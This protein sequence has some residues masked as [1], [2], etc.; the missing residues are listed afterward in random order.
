[1]STH[2][3]FSAERLGGGKP[4]NSRPGADLAGRAAELELM[5]SL[6]AGQGRDGG[7]LLLRGAPG[8]G[9]T[10]LLDAAAVRA[11]DAG[12][13]VLRASGVEFEA[14][15]KFSALHQ[16]LYP[17]RRQAK[18]LAGH[19]RDVLDRIFGLAPGPSP[20]PPA[21]STAVLALLGEVAVERPL[22][23]IVDDMPCV[24]RASATV[25]G[26]VVR[27]I[28][29][30]PVVFLAAAR[31]G[32]E[33]LSHQLQL[34]V[35][36]IGPLAAQSAAELL[37]VRWPG[38]A[39]T[40]RRRLLA[41]AA[42]NPL[43]LQE[44][45]AAL[46]SRQRSG[47]DPLPAFLALSGRL[48]TAFASAVE[49]LPAPTRR[50][51]L[52]AALNADACLTTIRK[53]ARDSAGVDDLAPA[54]RADLVHVDA[55]DGHISFRYP[56][57]RAAIVHLASPS[58][59]RG[60][61]RSLAAALADSPERR[62]W[63]LAEAATGPDESVARALDEAALA[64][65]R[66]GAPSG[67][68]A[69][70][71]DET[72]VSDRRRVAAS[73]AVAWLMRAGEL[74]PDPADRSRRLVEAAYL[75]TIT[76]QLEDVQRL[77]ADAGQSPD[78]STGLVFAAT[79]HLLT[80]DEGD[81]DAAY[82]LLARALDD[83]T[84]TAKGDDWG[85][86]GILYALLLVSLYALRPEPWQLLKTA[87]ARFDP[88]AVTPFRL[89]YDAYVDPTRAPEALRKGL[90]DAFAALPADAA[91]WQLIPLAF[92][93]V[94]MDTLSDYRYLVARMIERERDGGAIAMV[95]PALMLLCHDS[96][97][98]G[99]WDEAESLAQEGLDLA[100]VYGYHFWERQIRALLASG[101]A[102]RGD[103]DLAR[104]RSEE[105][106]NWAAPRGIEVTEAYAR[107]ARHLAAIGQ[108]DYEEA[109]VQIGRVD[110]SGAPSPGI[111]GRWVVLDLVEAAVRTGRTDEA[112]AHVAAAREAGIHRISPRIAMIT[113]GAAAVAAEE[114][115][116]GHLFEAAL[117]LPQAARWPWEH[118]R[119]QLAYGQWLRRARDSRARRHLSAALETFDRIGAEA[120]A[121]RARNE[122][123]ATGVA[124][125]AGP[126]A[127]TAVLT[128]QEGQIAELAA[129]GL[130][131]KQIGERLF[132]SHRTV[133]SHL[134]RMYPK[135]GITS[136][137]A[138]RVALEAMAPG[139]DDQVSLEPPAG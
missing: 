38:L 67:A 72:A 10:A 52:V 51:L 43:A 136:R 55:A 95:I 9:K 115:E 40:V 137:A 37:D 113:A 91:P 45:P 134:H 42:G 128:V 29:D 12:M 24:D 44:L 89:C 7:S 94:A 119:I 103:V 90:T 14:E 135:L 46:S 81:V 120:M 104:T 28:S 107:S 53:A 105:T 31:T 6:F 1:M 98:H 132:L 82:R 106:T 83:N 11:A 114:N 21:A 20:D 8:V 60:A 59:R 79:A 13:R 32:T 18:E 99:Q 17:L 101:A 139:G 66:R 62:A 78:T 122:L 64:I 87:M 110:P 61:H 124:T 133:G 33:G 112:R 100:E 125:T 70:A 27:R 92:A 96:Y 69:R 138:L 127:A 54:Q 65:W 4:V 80:N 123:R 57:D 50:V 76:G 85:C 23:M 36:E 84:D 126:D 58:E 130:T 129:T 86:Y 77:L 75:A 2:H 19:H 102:L 63:H 93:A 68:A 116:A 49:R 108:G 16:M 5:D 47:Q 26:F 121:Q 71:S 41:E 15:M 22:L 48:E 56:L 118:A 73:A 88:A 35:R 34:P 97:G 131:N 74:S 111:P 3:D 109:H 30:D 25:L 117:S 39:P